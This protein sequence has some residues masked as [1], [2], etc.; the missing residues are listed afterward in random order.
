MENNL[1]KKLKDAGVDAEIILNLILDGED[2]PQPV[3]EPEEQ[4]EKQ[5]EPEPEKKPDPVL[6]AIDKLT[7]MIIAGNI[8]RAYDDKSPESADDIIANILKG[9]ENGQET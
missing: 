1:I 3:P 8:R 7:G 5:P 2:T 4:P 6:E 9:G